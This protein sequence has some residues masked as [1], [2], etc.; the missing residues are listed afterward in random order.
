[1]AFVCDISIL[2]LHLISI[3]WGNVRIPR[4]RRC[5][6]PHEQRCYHVLLYTRHT[7]AHFRDK[8]HCKTSS[9]WSAPDVLY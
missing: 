3:S 7:L 5:E 8:I 4:C 6:W 9:V 1:M 2:I